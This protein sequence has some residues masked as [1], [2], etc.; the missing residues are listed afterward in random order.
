M[1]LFIATAMLFATAFSVHAESGIA[2]HYA[3]YDKDQTGSRVACKG[4]RLSNSAMV[5]AHRTRPCGSKVTVHRGGRSIVVTIIDRG[6]F[7]KGRVIDL[8]VGAARALGFA[9]TSH[10]TLN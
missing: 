5:A 8:S 6:P 4:Y 10:V 3:T 7:V 1:A 9:G 2:S